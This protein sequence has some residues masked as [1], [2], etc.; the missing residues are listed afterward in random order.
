MSSSASPNATTVAKAADAVN[1]TVRTN[2]SVG[3][4][5]GVVAKPPPAGKKPD[6]EAILLN[7]TNDRRKAAG[8]DYEEYD[9]SEPTLPPSLPNVR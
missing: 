4:L 8:E 6:I 1:V 5:Q 3:K 7:I 2:V 9:Y